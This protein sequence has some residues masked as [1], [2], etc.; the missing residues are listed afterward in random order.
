M[1]QENIIKFKGTKNGILIYIKPHHDFEIIKQ[2]L[3]DKIEKARFFFKG[4]KIFDIHCATL[5]LNKESWGID[6]NKI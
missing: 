2:Q 1:L 4:A 3:I 5:A 6:G